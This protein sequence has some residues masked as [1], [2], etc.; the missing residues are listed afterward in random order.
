MNNPAGKEKRNPQREALV[1]AYLDERSR[2][3]AGLYGQARQLIDE[4]DPQGWT[5]LVGH[6]G[7]ELMN[8]LADYEPVPV[9]DPDRKRGRTGAEQCAKRL[10]DARESGDTSA[11]EAAVDWMIEDFKAGHEATASRA[12]A[13]LAAA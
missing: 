12:E 11:L 5:Y 4:R 9:E 1:G 6:I 3:L 7:R 8:R 13:L 10:G 2:E